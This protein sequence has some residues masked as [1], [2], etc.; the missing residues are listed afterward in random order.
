MWKQVF[1]A[2]IIAGILD[3]TGACTQAYISKG[4]MPDVILQYIASG[5]FG[6]EAYSGGLGVMLFGLAVHFLIVCCIATTYFIAYPTMKWL[7]GNILLNA[8]LIALVAWTVTTQVIVPLSKIQP[9][10]FDIT[11]ALIAVG[12]LYF[13]IGL[14]ISFLAKQFYN[15]PATR[16]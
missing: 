2:T 7:H 13:C 5:L 11:K 12:I 6:K 4:V 14:P 1:K 16:N 10:A 3:M 8:A 15:R 9:P